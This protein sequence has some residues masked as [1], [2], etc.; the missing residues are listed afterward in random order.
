MRA[1]L[2]RVS[3][4]DRAHA[5]VLEPAAVGSQSRSKRTATCARSRSHLAR[6]L[7][8]TQLRSFSDERRYLG[9]RVVAH[10]HSEAA[11]S[12]RN[13]SDAV[14]SLASRAAARRSSSSVAPLGRGAST[15]GRGVGRHSS[16][17][18]KLIISARR[19]NR[20]GRKWKRLRDRQEPSKVARSSLTASVE[21]SPM[22][23]HR[24]DAKSTGSDAPESA[25]VSARPLLLY[26]VTATRSAASVLSV[27]SSWTISTEPLLVDPT[28][29][30]DWAD[31]P[32][33]L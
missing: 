18:S 13:A 19:V 4:S 31:S 7:R 16:T 14:K 28:P 5:V 30:G 10:L 21:A 32:S 1:V 17:R 33:N 29:D 12:A 3:S 26:L 9:E 20:S 6:E 27:A 25:G 23:P 22:A 8:A 24:F 2:I 15:A 11:S